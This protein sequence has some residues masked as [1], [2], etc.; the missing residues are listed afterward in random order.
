MESPQAMHDDHDLAK[1]GYKQELVRTL[2]S[3]STFATGFAFISILT[4]IVQLFAFA[5]A[6]AG[7]ASWWAWCVAAAGQL[8]FALAFAELAVHYPLAG[9][10]YNWAKQLAGPSVSWTAGFS[11]ILAL[12]VSTGAVALAMQFVLPS[13]SDVFWIYGDGT[14]QYDYATNAVILGSIMIVLTTAISLMGTRMISLV[15]NIG[16][17]VELISVV[18]LILFFVLHARRGPGV[19]LDTNGTGTSHSLGTLGALLAAVLIGLYVMWGFDTAGSVGEETI[20][21]RKTNPKAIIRALLASGILGALLI[22]SALMATGNLQAEELTTGGLTYVIKDVLGE[23]LGD[24]MLICLATAI[25]VCGLANQTGAVRMI[26]AMA[27]DNALPGSGRLA[28]VSAGAKAPAAPILIVAAAAVLVLVVNIRQPA[29]FLVVTSGTVILAVISYVLV[30]GPFALKRIRRE[31]HQTDPQYFSLGR[32]GL[33]VSIAAFVWG[34][35]MIINIAW[36]REGIYN[37]FEPFHWWLRW[38]GVLFPAVAL[39]LGYA[40]FSLI[41]RNKLGVLAEHAAHRTDAGHLVLP[42]DEMAAD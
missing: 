1:F 12:T 15:N 29:I 40:W 2:G 31:W 21:P 38:G 18:L 35:T 19:V 9:S 28:R 41:Q 8:L 10:V 39:G 30:V 23:T 16:V 5:V 34:V 14:G 33:P 22:M 7:P 6:T 32:L 25:F 24:L 26:F 36:P 17:S 20:N 3:F 4:G 37:P 27:R 13:I 42:S 11:L